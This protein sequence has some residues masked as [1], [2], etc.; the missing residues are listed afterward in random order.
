MKAS[1]LLIY[2]QSVIQTHGDCELY[3]WDPIN[4]KHIGIND[5]KYITDIY[6][7]EKLGNECPEYCEN[8][9]NIKG[10]IILE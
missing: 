10:N 7:S 1:E 9:N 4:M 2:L 3:H 5:V 6:Y 8:F